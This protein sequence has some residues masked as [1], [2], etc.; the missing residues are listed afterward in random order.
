MTWNSSVKIPVDAFPKLGFAMVS[1][2]AVMIPPDW[3]KCNV[4]DKVIVF[5]TNLSA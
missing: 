1:M 5:Q 4:K 3:T 2:I